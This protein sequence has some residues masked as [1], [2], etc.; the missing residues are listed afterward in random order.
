M[1]DNSKKSSRP[2]ESLTIPVREAGAL[3]GYKPG[4]VEK[5]LDER[6][7]PLKI[8][9]LGRNLVCLR[10]DVDAYVV[11]LFGRDV[12]GQEQKRDDAPTKA[13]RGPGRPRKVTPESES[14]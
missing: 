11:R 1:I 12:P 7:F 10:S 9:K 4:T 13:K 3:I 6:R 14:V 2:Q 5:L 8:A